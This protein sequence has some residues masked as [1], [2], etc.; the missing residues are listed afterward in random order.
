MI[1]PLS[2]REL[3]C[4][5]GLARGLSY[6]EIGAEIYLSPWT[7]KIYMKTLFRKLGARSGSH[8]V[9]LGYQKQLLT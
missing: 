8:A 5:E 2:D 3:A 9:A 6:Q 1:V 7:V 4:L